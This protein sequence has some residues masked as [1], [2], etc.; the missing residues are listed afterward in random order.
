MR[1]P[2]VFLLMLWILSPALSQPQ[3]AEPFG[4]AIDIQQSYWIVPNISY[5]VAD[6]YESKLDVYA[7]RSTAGPVPTV[8][9]IHG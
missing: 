2:A 4:W 5:S 9:N 3:P 8:I 1:T 7:R 6:G